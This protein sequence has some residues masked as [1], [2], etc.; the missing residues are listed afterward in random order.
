MRAAI[1]TIVL[2]L[3]CH[4]RTPPF[5]PTGTKQLIR[6]AALIS[7]QQVLTIFDNEFSVIKHK[8]STH[9]VKIAEVR[10]GELSA[11]GLPGVY[12][13]WKND[14]GVIKVGKHQKNAIRRAL[15]HL[16]DNTKN[17]KIQMQS[18]EG[19]PNCTLIVFLVSGEQDAHWVP[20]VELFMEKNTR[21]IIPSRRNG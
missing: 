17:E 8:F 3:D 16:R 5:H 2:L 4:G 20:S 19:D 9:Q 15:E 10:S 11:L 18:L 1:D 12:I 21:P 13:F 14:L 7:I 6:E